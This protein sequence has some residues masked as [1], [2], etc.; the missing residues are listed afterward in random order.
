MTHEIR[1]ETFQMGFSEQEVSNYFGAGAKSSLALPAVFGRHPAE[2]IFLSTSSFMFV[3]FAIYGWWWD[4]LTRTLTVSFVHFLFLSLK[5]FLLPKSVYS[6]NHIQKTPKKPPK[7]QNP[8]K[9]NQKKKR[10]P[11]TS[12]FPISL[13]SCLS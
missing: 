12:I 11:L 6:L 5:T 4:S 13:P 10:S 9:R 1:T 7:N 2:R 8:K 3:Y